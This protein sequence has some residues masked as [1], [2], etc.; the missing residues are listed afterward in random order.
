MNI[1]IIF[2]DIFELEI[3]NIKTWFNGNIKKNTI[4]LN[5]YYK[6]YQE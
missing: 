3:T 6:I 5:N 1:F 4:N 2:I